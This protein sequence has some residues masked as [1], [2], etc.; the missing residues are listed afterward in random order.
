VLDKLGII[1]YLQNMKGDFIDNRLTC[2]YIGKR[3]KGKLKYFQKRWFII[4][5][6]KSLVLILYNIYLK[7][8]EEYNDEKILDET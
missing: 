4:V 8:P 2:G 3:S 7:Y 6:A 5:S 1:N